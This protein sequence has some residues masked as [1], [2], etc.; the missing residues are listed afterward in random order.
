MFKKILFPTTGSSSCDDAARVAFDMAKRYAAELVVL[1]WASLETAE[2]EAFF[3][4]LGDIRFDANGQLFVFAA[5]PLVLQGYG[6]LPLGLA[7]TAFGRQSGQHA[8]VPLPT[9]SREQR[10]I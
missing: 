8:L 1:K 5:E 9:P 2:P 6:I 7:A 10:R 3:D 4:D